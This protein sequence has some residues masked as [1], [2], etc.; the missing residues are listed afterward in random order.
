M[1]WPVP[2]QA[3]QVRATAE[4]ALLVADLSTA[5]ALAADGGPAAGG[6]A[7]AVAGAAG[8]EAADLDLGLDAEDGGLEVDGQVEAQVVAA[9]LAVGA[10][11]IAAHRK[12]LAEQIAEDVANIDA[13][14][15]RARQSP[16]P[17]R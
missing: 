9:L 10:M 8:L 7:A 17:L 3:G 4:E 14:G 12:H 11:R 13:T 15:E 16:G 1:T 5:L 2:P 6:A